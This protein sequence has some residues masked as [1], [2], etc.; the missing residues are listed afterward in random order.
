VEES[1]QSLPFGDNLSCVTTALATADDATEHHFTGKERDAESGNDYFLAR[2][3]S[4]TMG[5]FMSPDWSAKEEPIP[6]AVLGDPQSLNLYA[7]VRNNPLSKTD[8]DGHC[9]WCQKLKNGLEGN[10]L[11]TDAEV[12]ALNTPPPPPSLPKPP[13]V[14][15]A[16]PLKYKPGVPVPAPNSGLGKLL[17]CTNNCMNPVQSTVSST[18][19]ATPVHPKGTPHREGDAADIQPGKGESKS[20]LMCA[21]QCGAK[22]GQNEYLHPSPHSTGGHDHIQTTPGLGGS[23]GDLPKDQ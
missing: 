10:G 17:Q 6:Y 5:R 21:A 19:E 8:P 11:R 23:R 14:P 2:Y 20:G 15:P 9:D 4:S 3:Y 18:S 16:P 12:K 7:Y 13:S 1:C 22:F